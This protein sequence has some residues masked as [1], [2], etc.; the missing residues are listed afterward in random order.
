MI[1]LLSV[2]FCIAITADYYYRLAIEIR[3]EGAASF[4]TPRLALLL[5][6]I[7]AAISRIA[8]G[9]LKA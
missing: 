8:A 9:W 1:R 3:F 5:I 6:E 7:A 2:Y 4:G